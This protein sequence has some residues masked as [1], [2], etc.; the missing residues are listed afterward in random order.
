MA[1]PAFDV[2]GLIIPELIPLIAKE[3]AGGR[4]SQKQREH[5]R[6]DPRK[7]SRASSSIIGSISRSRR[8]DMQE[9]QLQS[10]CPRGRLTRYS[11]LNSSA[12]P[13]H[14]AGKIRSRTRQKPREGDGESLNEQVWCIVELLPRKTP[15]KQRAI[16]MMNDEL[17]RDAKRCLCAH[18]TICVTIHRLMFALIMKFDDTTSGNIC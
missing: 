17:W 5:Y 4:Q 12:A 1:N 8:L 2:D 7:N 16:L 14:R 11:P 6:S 10:V 9:R 3:G 13:I 18:Y 15:E